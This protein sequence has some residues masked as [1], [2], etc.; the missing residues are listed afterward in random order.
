MFHVKQ[1]AWHIRSVSRETDATKTTSRAETP[2]FHVKH[3]RGGI[4]TA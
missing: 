2:L 3:R 1:A 4:L